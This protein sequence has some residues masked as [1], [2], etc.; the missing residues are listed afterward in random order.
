[1]NDKN[2]IIDG[3]VEILARGCIRYLTQKIENDY[4][5]KKSLDFRE[6]V[7]TNTHDLSS[8]VR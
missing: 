2:E 3:I 7:S 5:S 4:N 8:K 1:M 6:I